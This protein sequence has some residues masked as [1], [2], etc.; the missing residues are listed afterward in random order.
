MSC[1]SLLTVTVC[2]HQHSFLPDGACALSFPLLCDTLLTPCVC[3]HPVIIHLSVGNHTMDKEDLQHMM[4]YVF[5]DSPVQIQVVTPMGLI[6]MQMGCPAILAV[7]VALI[8]LHTQETG[9]MTCQGA[10]RVLRLQNKPEVCHSDTAN[11]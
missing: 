9:L 4:H 10:G 5:T 7:K 6:A 8:T 2:Q 11:V 1:V 3:V